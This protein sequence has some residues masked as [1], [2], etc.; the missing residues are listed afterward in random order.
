MK[1]ASRLGVA[2]RARPAP[3]PAR[4]PLGPTS[5]PA[6]AP[7]RLGSTESRRVGDRGGCRRRPGDQPERRRGAGC[8]LA[9]TGAQRLSL[10]GRGLGD[11]RPQAARSPEM[12]RRR[13]CRAR[14]P[15]SRLLEIATGSL[16]RLPSSLFNA[17]AF[18]ASLMRA[19]QCSKRVNITQQGDFWS[20]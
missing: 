10:R 7:G 2:G 4:L 5:G 19:F 16:S 18:T 14:G 20:R 9:R 17:R 6:A 8:V 12:P 1:A 13:P 11:G 3:T 15:A